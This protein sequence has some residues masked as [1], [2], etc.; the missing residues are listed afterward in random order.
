MSNR[1]AIANINKKEEFTEVE[2]VQL[3]FSNISLK[4]L[5]LY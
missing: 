3:Q 4:S 5:K 2:I 1:S